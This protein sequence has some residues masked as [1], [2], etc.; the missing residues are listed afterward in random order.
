MNFYIMIYFSSHFSQRNIQLDVFMFGETVSSRVTGSYNY[1]VQ[2]GID[3]SRDSEFSQG[4][5]IIGSDQPDWIVG[6]KQNNYI[7]AGKGEDF[8][9]GKEGYDVYVI[10]Q[11]DGL[12]HIFQLF[13]G[14]TNMDTILFDADYEDIDLIKEDLYFGLQAYKHTSNYLAVALS[15][16]FY[17]DRQSLS[18]YQLTASLQSC[19]SLNKLYYIKTRDGIVFKI[20]NSANSAMV[21]MPEMVDY[22][23]TSK[24]LTAQFTQELT[25]AKRFIGSTNYD[26]VVGNSLTNYI[27]PGKGGCYLEGRDGSD[28]YVIKSDYGTDNGIYNQATDYAMDTLLFSVPY[29]SISVQVSGT[30]VILTSSTDGNSNAGVTLYLYAASD[31]ERHLVVVTGDGI[32]FALPPDKNYAPTPLIINKSQMKT[33]QYINLEANSQYSEVKTMYGSNEFENHLVGNQ[34]KN[35]VVGG[36]K[37]DLL[38][39]LDGDDVLKGGAGRDTLQGGSGADNLAGGPDD[40]TLYGQDG[41]DFISPG[42]GSNVVYGGEGVDTVVYGESGGIEALLSDNVIYHP[43]DTVVDRVYEVENVFG[44]NENDILQGDDNDNVLMGYNGNDELYTGKSGSDLLNGGEGSDTYSWLR[45]VQAFTSDIDATMIVDNYATDGQLDTVV[46]DLIVQ[47]RSQLGFEKSNNDLVIRK[48]NQQY[49]VFYEKGP[50]VVLKNWFHPEQP[51]LYRHIQLRLSE[52]VVTNSQ[53]E[54]IGNEAAQ[55]EQQNMLILG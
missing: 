23:H 34:L 47:R 53:L 46:H 27:D 14:D 41:N 18:R 39:G 7:S 4:V 43:H 12:N 48:I 29:D 2:N 42:L 44:T 21:K 54:S 37:D 6:N 55:R 38:Q 33:G 20:P 40:D 49:P 26:V 3:L 1:Q 25:Q 9:Y 32:T 15:C 45:A 31:A 11:G 36:S 35:T 30:E 8:L 19:M 50:I 52:E 10:K 17:E 28:T 13:D 5:T 16:L 51:E 22:S 24:M